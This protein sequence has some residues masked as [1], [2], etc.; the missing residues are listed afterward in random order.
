MS[1]I[2]PP[3]DYAP[4]FIVPPGKY[5]PHLYCMAGSEAFLRVMVIEA[6]SDDFHI[7]IEDYPRG[8]T[9]LWVPAREVARREDIDLMPAARRFPKLIEADGGK[10]HIPE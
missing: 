7:R 10:I 8:S 6:C 5:T 9:R 4:Q 2:I 1:L 3:P